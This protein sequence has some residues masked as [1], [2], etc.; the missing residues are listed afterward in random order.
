[1]ATLL[2]EVK[3]ERDPEREA[4]GLAALEEKIR[5][6]VDMLQQERQA[7]RD[8][9][10]EV[11]RLSESTMSD[12]KHASTLERELE[13]LRRE[14]GEVKTRVERLVQQLDELAQG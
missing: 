3:Q 8:A 4:D 2:A 11:A 10:A 9:E 5:R 14:R 7:R 13:T 6:A 1:M 12:R